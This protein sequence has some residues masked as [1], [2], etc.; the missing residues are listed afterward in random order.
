MQLGCNLTH[1]KG[2][3]LHSIQN[4]LFVELT[5]HRQGNGAE[6]YDTFLPHTKDNPWI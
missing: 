4:T 2:R 3:D 6:A 5:R 1:S